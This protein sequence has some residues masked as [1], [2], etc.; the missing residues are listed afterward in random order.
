MKRK[1]KEEKEFTYPA[2][3][4]FKYHMSFGPQLKS[5]DTVCTLCCA[6]TQHTLACIDISKGSPVCGIPENDLLYTIISFI[7]I[8]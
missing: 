5:N 1:W 6:D 8:Y 3:K 7:E 2:V 4:K